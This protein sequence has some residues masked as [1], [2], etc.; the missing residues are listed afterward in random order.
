ME[1]KCYMEEEDEE[2]CIM[3]TSYDAECAAKDFAKRWDDDYI[4][5]N[6]ETI[7]ITKD[8]DGNIRKFW[9]GVEPDVYWWTREIE[10]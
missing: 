8:P 10:E 2:E 5:M 9:V 4:L 6:S 7:V 1:F 3:M